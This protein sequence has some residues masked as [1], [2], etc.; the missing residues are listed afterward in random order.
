MALK[1]VVVMLQ[2]AIARAG[3]LSTRTKFMVETLNNLKNNKVK[4]LT[5][6]S[7]V[8]ARAAVRMKKQLG[9]LNSRHLRATEPL[10]PT[11]KDIKEVEAKGKWW[12]VGSGSSMS[13]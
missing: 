13:F 4:S 10:R 12:L 8:S 5:S 11:L 1:S 9:M 7:E 6:T 2:P 3:T